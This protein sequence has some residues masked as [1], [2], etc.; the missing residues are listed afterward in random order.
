MYTHVHTDTRTRLLLMWPLALDLRLQ[1][2]HHSAGD[3]SSTDLMGETKGVGGSN[4]AALPLNT[5][6]HNKRPLSAA[7]WALGSTSAWSSSS[8]WAASKP[9]NS[10]LRAWLCHL[11]CPSLHGNPSLCRSGIKRSGSEKPVFS[12]RTDYGGFCRGLEDL[13]WHLS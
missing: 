2:W 3:F 9:W 13:D 10:P 11:A 4:S 8:H 6:H 5:S 12:L 7:V 1:P